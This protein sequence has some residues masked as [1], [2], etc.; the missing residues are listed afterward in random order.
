MAWPRDWQSWDRL[1]DLSNTFTTYNQLL[2]VT[3]VVF[4]VITSVVIAIVVGP[5]CLLKY[6]LIGNPVKILV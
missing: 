6:W 3:R 5:K 1:V 2:F 4:I